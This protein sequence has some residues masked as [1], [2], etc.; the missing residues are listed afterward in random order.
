MTAQEY[1]ELAETARVNGWNLRPEV[2]INVGE[3]IAAI[4]KRRFPK[5][6]TAD[7]APIQR[8]VRE[9]A[10]ALLSDHK[11]NWPDRPRGEK[12]NFYEIITDDL[13]ISHNELFIAA[14]A[15]N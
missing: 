10:C 6:D 8:A 11:G 2:I 7:L 12:R 13:L 15:K 4:L 9:R 14:L 5:S 1:T 3:G